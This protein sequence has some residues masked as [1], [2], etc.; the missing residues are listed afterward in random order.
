[1]PGRFSIGRIVVAAL[2]SY[3]GP[4]PVVAV[5]SLDDTVVPYG[6][7]LRSC[8]ECG[9]ANLAVIPVE[10]AGHMGFMSADVLRAY[11]EIFRCML[12]LAKIV[13]LS[14]MD[15]ENNNTVSLFEAV[16][17]SLNV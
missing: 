7:I 16:W 4:D 9:A 8:I 11:Q 5:A 6:S 3:S 17:P 1:M 2:V 15:L 13:G 14:T 10:R 12:P